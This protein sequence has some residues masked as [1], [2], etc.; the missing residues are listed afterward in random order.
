[1]RYNKP[2]FELTCFRRYLLSRRFLVLFCGLSVALCALSPAL[3]ASKI[4]N[5]QISRGQG[6]YFGQGLKP[7][8]TYQIQVHSLKAHQKFTALLLENYTYIQNHQL[9]TGHKN[10]QVSGTTPRTISLAQPTKAQLSGW[11]LVGQV[12]LNSSAGI[13]VRMYDEGTKKKKK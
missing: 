6:V 3:A 2:P 11:V 12:R 5:K 4:I 10:L 1:M 7:S 8:H 13:D 9:L